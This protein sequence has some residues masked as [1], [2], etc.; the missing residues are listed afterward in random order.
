LFRT[1]LLEKTRS[2]DIRGQCFV[3]HETEEDDIDAWVAH[4]DHYYVNQ[5]AGSLD[6][7]SLDDLE[8]WS[9]RGFKHCVP[10]YEEHQGHLARRAQQL[11]R[12]GP[13]R[14]LELF[15]GLTTVFVLLCDSFEPI[16]EGAGG[17]GTGLDLSGFVE[18]R[19]AIEFSPGAAKTYES[20]FFCDSIL[21]D[22]WLMLSQTK[23]S[24][25]CGV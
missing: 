9:G 7:R 19:Y 14:G 24:Q 18:T 5:C 13:L 15:S 6:P 3:I 22:S 11:Q 25:R 12:Y 20:V 10:C 2:D 23:P 1:P 4:D 17:L 8:P 16:F 21:D